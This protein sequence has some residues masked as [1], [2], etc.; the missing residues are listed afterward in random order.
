VTELGTSLAAPGFSDVH[1]ELV[2]IRKTRGLSIDSV[3][4]HGAA[5]RLLPVVNHELMR[6]RWT[7]G[8]RT[9]AVLN[10]VECAISR[11][12]HHDYAVILKHTLNIAVLLPSGSEPKETIDKRLE[13]A[14][15]ELCWSSSSETHLKKMYKQAYIELASLLSRTERSPCEGDIQDVHRDALARL[16]PQAI[17]LVESLMALGVGPSDPRER[18]LIKNAGLSHLPVGAGIAFDEPGSARFDSLVMWALVQRY[19]SRLAPNEANWP[20]G[21]L[22]LELLQRLLFDPRAGTPEHLG[23]VWVQVQE[24]AGPISYGDFYKMVASSMRY[25]ALHLQ[26]EEVT[27]WAQLAYRGERLSEMAALMSLRPGIVRIEITVEDGDALGFTH[28]Q[29]EVL[30]AFSRGETSAEIAKQLNISA[31]TVRSHLRRMQERLMQQL[32]TD[33]PVVPELIATQ[34]AEVEALTKTQSLVN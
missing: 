24:H 20:D 21:L 26:V 15:E 16:W 8:D 31:H 33:V 11:A 23:S 18:E 17:S 9:S 14:R 10:V 12:V 7:E 13:A 19:G 30:Q 1:R 3:E 22:R 25:L 34:I 5:L 32:G 28:R 4:R 27:G 2:K 6:R 29:M